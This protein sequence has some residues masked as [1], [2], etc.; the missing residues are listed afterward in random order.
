M[1]CREN[2]TAH[3]HHC[4]VLM[5]AWKEGAA[6][7]LPRHRCCSRQHNIQPAPMHGLPVPLQLQLADIIRDLGICSLH[8]GHKVLKP[9]QQGTARDG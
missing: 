4:P 6:A 9:A 3:L 2:S 5:D 1:R 8:D 7:A